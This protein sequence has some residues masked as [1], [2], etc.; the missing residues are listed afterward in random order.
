[1]KGK[2]IEDEELPGFIKFYT[3]FTFSLLRK[4]DIH[5]Y[6]IMK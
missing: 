1:M 6:Q 4:H 2:V 5:V 3:L